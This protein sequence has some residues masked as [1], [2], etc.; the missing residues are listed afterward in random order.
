[1][2]GGWKA[3]AMEGHRVGPGCGAEECRIGRREV[4]KKSS[5][6]PDRERGRAVTTPGLAAREVRALALGRCFQYCLPS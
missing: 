5:K 2:G 4:G 6:T 3:G 1:M